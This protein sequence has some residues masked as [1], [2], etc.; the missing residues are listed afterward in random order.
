M[1]EKSGG[2]NEVLK[3]Q[4]KNKILMEIG[5]DSFGLPLKFNEHIKLKKK[6]I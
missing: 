3:S 2:K 5:I 1:P 4:N 6:K